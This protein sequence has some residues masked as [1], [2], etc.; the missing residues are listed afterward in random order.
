[1]DVHDLGERAGRPWHPGGRSRGRWLLVALAFALVA[2]E[3]RA[4]T[5]K[6]VQ[7]KM[8]SRFEITVV[9]EREAAAWEAVAAAWAEVDR[10]EALISEWRPDSETSRVNDRAGQGPVVVSK[11]LF[12]LVRR[13]IKVS[14]LTGGAF[15]ITFAGAGKLWDF[16]ADPP[17]LPDPAAIERALADVDYRLV[18]LD[19]GAS[20]IELPRPGMRIGF[21]AIGKGYAANR[22]AAL[23]QERGIRDGVINAGGDLAA[24]GHREDGEP[25]TVGIADPR[26]P[27]QVFAY[28]QASGQSVV[29]SGDYESFIEVDGVRYA[30]ILDPRT[31]FPAR[32]VMSV[33]IVCP[34]AELADALATGVFVLGREAGLALV[35]RLNGVEGLVV[36]GRGEL[37]FSTGL[38]S[39]FLDRESSP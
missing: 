2:V 27:D 8:G 18:R 16:K 34:D 17:R 29:T 12:E 4:A 22:V 39:K 1:M 11:E 5:V 38:E 7:K 33:T 13:S 3:A 37:H 20:T 28:L 31:G 24:F 26:R 21:G 10:I 6:D 32:D 35:D 9:H 36:D 14:E 30:H 19:R 25:W 15:D 23:L